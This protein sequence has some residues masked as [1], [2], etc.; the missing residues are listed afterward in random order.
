MEIKILVNTGDGFKEHKPEPKVIN[1][2]KE[3][4]RLQV[5]KKENPKTDWSKVKEHDKEKA[6][7][8]ML[9]LGKKYPEI[10][11]YYHYFNSYKSRNSYYVIMKQA[12]IHYMFQIQKYESSITTKVIGRVVG[13]THATVLTHYRLDERQRHEDYNEVVLLMDKMIKQDLYPVIDHKNK[14]LK[15]M[16]LWKKIN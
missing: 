1:I 9:E 15:T 10:M 13:L 16:Y 4:M 3:L 5:I 14:Q 2:I 8:T 7:E 6:Y 11:T 12:V